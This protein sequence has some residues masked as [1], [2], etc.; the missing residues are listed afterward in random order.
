MTIN[1]LGPAFDGPIPVIPLADVLDGRFDRALVHDRIV[2]IGLAM[3]GV[4]QHV[5][6]T[7]GATRMWGLAVLA[8]AVET[9]LQQR[10]LR[11]TTRALVVAATFSLA[12]GGAGLVAVLRPAVA[13]LAV[14]AL[15][16]AYLTGAVAAFDRGLVLD[17]VYP[18]A[19]LVL[20]V[21]GALGARLVL[22]HAEQRMLREVVSR[23]L[24]PAVRDWMLADPSRL[25]LGGEERRMTVLFTGLRG[26][27]TMAHRLPPPILVAVLTEYRTAMTHAVFAHDGVPAQYAGDAI[28]ALGVG[29]HTGVLVVGNMGS[30]HRLDDSAV[31]DAVNVAARLEGLSKAYGVHVGGGDAQ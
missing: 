10:Y 12:L 30:H 21:G 26:C 6:P 13:A 8:N 16:V 7:S 22:E 4:D 14:G 2:L 1:F 28:E 31:G 3:G 11:P 18:P 29:V 23:Y 15:L 9:I 17:L 27:T 19:P 5:T 20:A 25:R 24:S